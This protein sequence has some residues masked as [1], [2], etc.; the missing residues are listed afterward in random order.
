MQLC[1]LDILLSRMVFYCSTSV[2]GVLCVD[3]WNRDRL[4]AFGP[5]TDV[6]LDELP[7]HKF[8]AR[9]VFRVAS[10]LLSHQRRRSAIVG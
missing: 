9:Q 3:L 1:C 10:Q 4:P 6:A 2:L 5:K 7:N 8:L